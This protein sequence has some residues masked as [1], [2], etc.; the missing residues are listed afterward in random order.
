[1]ALK[2]HITIGTTV[3]AGLVAL[4][5]DVVVIK[6]VVPVTVDQLS[7]VAKNVPV[8]FVVLTN[9]EVLPVVG[10]ISRWVASDNIGGTILVV[11]D[12]AGESIVATN[13]MEVAWLSRFPDSN[14]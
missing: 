14:A 13:A 11:P 7:V 3:S 10:E 5:A 12:I 9:S 8:I 1:M 2:A 6:V 4:L